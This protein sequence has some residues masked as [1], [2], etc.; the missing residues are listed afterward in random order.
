[1]DP[2]GGNAVQKSKNYAAAYRNH[3]FPCYNSCWDSRAVASTGSGADL[4]WSKHIVS[5]AGPYWR[6]F[7]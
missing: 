1:M 4:K 3:N 2:P 6:I 7:G 5:V